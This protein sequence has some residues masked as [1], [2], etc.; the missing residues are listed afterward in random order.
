[1]LSLLRQGGLAVFDNVLWGGA[2]ADARERDR[3]T[4]G[5]RALNQKLHEDE[6]IDVCLLAMGD[7]VTLARKR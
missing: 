4:S 7:G 6:R 3:T 2:V 1:V 5:L